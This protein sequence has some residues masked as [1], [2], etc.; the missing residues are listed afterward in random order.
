MASKGTVSKTGPV[1]IYWHEVVSFWTVKFNN[2]GLQKASSQAVQYAHILPK[3]LPNLAGILYATC[4]KEK[5]Y[6]FW[7][8]NSGIVR[9]NS[10]PL[11]HDDTCAAL[12]HQYI[13]TLVNLLAALEL[14]TRDPTMKAIAPSGENLKATWR[15][16]INGEP[17]DCRLLVATSNHSR[18]TCVFETVDGNQIVK[19]HWRD[20][21]R[22]FPVNENSILEKV[23]GVP[24]VVQVACSEDV[25]VEI[26]GKKRTQKR[27]LRTSALHSGRKPRY[28]RT[29][30]APRRTKTRCLL[31]SK[32]EPLS[33]RKSVLEIL[34]A[35]FDSVTGMVVSTLAGCF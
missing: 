16:E 13:S 23:K 18:Q 9:S 29:V 25:E 19:D 11:A 31:N 22:R 35:I 10:S 28:H 15:I 34:Q 14:S 7:S 32:G 2:A 27:K 21:D 1:R 17:Y 33:S 5:I 20:D 30:P 8:D 6:F 3:S 24:G 26:K 12:L 4:S